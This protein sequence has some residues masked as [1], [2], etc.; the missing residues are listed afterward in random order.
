M[1]TAED[2]SGVGFCSNNV[3]TRCSGNGISGNEGAIMIENQIDRGAVR[4]HHVESLD[5]R[6]HNFAVGPGQL[7]R[8]DDLIGRTNV[9]H[10]AGRLRRVLS[11]R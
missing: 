5:R 6:T 9:S 10:H 1:T 4:H 8:G 7:R 11:H 2:R 3:I